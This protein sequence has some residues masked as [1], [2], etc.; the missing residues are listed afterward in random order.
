VSQ[1][2]RLVRQ[3]VAMGGGGFSQ[4]PDNPLLDDFVLALSGRET[5]RVCFVPTASGDA[6]GYIDKFYEYFAEKRA[7]ASHLSLF[8]KSDVTDFK[9]FLLGQDVIY[10]GGGSTANMLA[11][12]R[13]HG[14]DR[15]L[16]A[17]WQKG[18]ILAGIS[19]GMNCWFQESVTDSFG[20]ELMPLKDGLGLLEGSACPHYDSEPG[21]RRGYHGLVGEGKLAA[22]YAADDGA[23]LHFIGTELAEVVASRP[24]A[25]GYKVALQG[26]EVKEMVLA[27]RCLA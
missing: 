26:G 2:I 14:I 20:G 10:V 27:S 9:D 6:Q 7:R 21:R 13:V 18:V 5:P 17:A 16:R 1:E 3:I 4:E 24:E 11:I 22:G 25:R 23:A 12:W 8:R 15:I 19:A